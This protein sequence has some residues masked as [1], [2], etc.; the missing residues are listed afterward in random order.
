MDFLPQVVKAKYQNGYRIHLT[1]ND[2][3]EKTVDFRQ[4]LTGPV[5]EPLHDTRY[6]RN[7]FLDGGTVSWPN[8]ADIAPETV[9]ESGEPK[10]AQQL[11]RLM[12]NE[13]KARR[14]LL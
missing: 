1:F 10:Q 8:G 9:Y 7:F 4:W 11:A 2:G 12:T 5:F 13:R 6:F 3:S 14:H